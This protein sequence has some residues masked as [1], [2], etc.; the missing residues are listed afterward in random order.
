M[1]EERLI[2]K[3]NGVAIVETDEGYDL[4]EQPEGLFIKTVDKL[5]E[6]REEAKGFK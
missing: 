4:L 1:T 3:T 2:E 5:E 6:A